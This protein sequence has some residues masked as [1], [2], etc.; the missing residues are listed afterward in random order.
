ME[1]HL[2]FLAC[3]ISNAYIFRPSISEFFSQSQKAG[4][5]DRPSVRSCPS[6][7]ANRV[8]SYIGATFSFS[9]DVPGE[10][11]ELV[12]VAD[13]LGDDNDA[14][15]FVAPLSLSLPAWLLS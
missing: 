14:T 5:R 15:L 11:A 6:D 2:P 13:G 9:L 8:D 12:V 7:I 3:V 4:H 10:A 1:W